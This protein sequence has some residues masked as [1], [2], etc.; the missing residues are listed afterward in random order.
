[1]RSRHRTFP[2]HLAGVLASALAL[3]AVLSARPA[4]AAPAIPAAPSAACAGDQVTQATGGAPARPLA[5][6]I[7]VLFVHGMNSSP[8]VWQGQSSSSLA[9]QVARVPGM[10]AWTFDYQ[11]QS[12]DWVTNAAIGPALASAIDC[13]AG[14]SGRSVFVVAHSLGGLAVQYA[15]EAPGTAAAA[16]VAEVVTIGTPFTGSQ[17]L[18]DAEGITNGTVVMSPAGA[19]VEAVLSACAGIATH[20]DS[21]PCW[22]ASVI[23]APVGTALESNS[24]QIA[25]LPAWPSSV[26]VLDTAGNINVFI[27]VDHIGFHVHP[28]DGAVT[29]P[30]A[31]A[32]DTVASP[33]VVNC[34][35]NPITVFSKTCFHT[36]LPENSQIVAAILAAIRADRPLSPGTYPVN[37]VIT[38]YSGWLVTLEKVRVS[39]NG[40]ATFVIT[41][42]NVSAGS[43]GY[44]TCTGI[45]DPG[46]SS[47]TLQDGQEVRSIATYCS[48]HPD[49]ATIKVPAGK[50][51]TDSTTF[52]DSAGL[53]APFDF[54][55]QA[56]YN[57][58]G[59]LPGI[60]LA[61]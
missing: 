42:T 58:S 11:H 46:A 47:I 40:T 61:G 41:F 36:H 48:G 33:V 18:T 27:G 38:N 39:P 49:Q 2:R 8:G 60:T 55:W 54:T 4:S 57:L 6:S 34:G 12:L 16:H 59:T 35:A 44:L 45:T 30:S 22:L 15:L 53:A 31:T 23:R 7:P 10:T 13:L 26:P 51:F 17:V 9:G 56:G 29:L 19:Y 32:H 43:P 28:G 50:T 20:S 3:A 25:Q 1:M 14:Q 37:R 21:N 52:A 24:Q 5:G